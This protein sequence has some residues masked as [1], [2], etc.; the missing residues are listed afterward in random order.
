MEAQEN[1]LN[2]E[3]RGFKDLEELKQCL[4]RQDKML[5]DKLQIT[6]K[7]ANDTK[8]E[9]LETKTKINMKEHL[10]ALAE[11]KKKNNNEWK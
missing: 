10:K 1:K 3:L 11:A 6:E 4:D 8:N 5:Q 7:R 2:D 9:Y